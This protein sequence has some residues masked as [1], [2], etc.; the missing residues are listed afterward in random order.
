MAAFAAS[1]AVAA[2]AASPAVA[3]RAERERAPT[4]DGVLL[5]MRRYP[6]PGAPP[7]LLL[8]GL[9][10]NLNGWDLPVEGHSLAQHLSLKGF[11]VWLGNFRGHGREPHRSGSGARSA[12]IDDF[13][14]F[15]VPAFVQRIVRATGRAPFIVGHSMGGIATLIHLIG[16]YSAEGERVC[17]DDDLAGAR[18]AELPG[19]VL[20]GTP[21]ALT[22]HKQLGPASLLRG[23]Y[24]EYN[25]LFQLILGRKAVIGLLDRLPI[26]RFATRAVAESA[27]A[28]SRWPGPLRH[29]PDGLTRVV[30]HAVSEVLAHTL[31]NP[32]NMTSALVDA[33][34]KF[35]LDDVSRAVLRQFVDWIRHETAREYIVGGMGPPLVYADHLDRVVT[36]ILWV[37]GELDRVAPP[38]VMRSHGLSRIKSPDRACLVLRGFGHND[39]RMGKHAPTALFPAVERW[40][41]DR[42]FVA[43][44][45]VIEG[46]AQSRRTKRSR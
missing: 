32:R 41:S 36:P 26:R 43:N 4:S 21:P 31:W 11:D 9:A 25:E 8:H 29:L 44:S 30:G 40:L 33:E 14:V 3:V 5:G 35:T 15:D 2:F 39:L 22:W 38:S 13:G 45:S 27:E 1:P 34:L 23:E 7:V 10:Q 20:V 46:Q 42:A 12:R 19:L 6:R 17:R 16:A 28:G 37:A 24:F 18:N